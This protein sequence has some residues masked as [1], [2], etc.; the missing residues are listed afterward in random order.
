VVAAHSIQGDGARFAHGRY[1]LNRYKG[2]YAELPSVFFYLP[3][4]TEHLL[5]LI[6]TD[7]KKSN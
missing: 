3:I 4:A 1:P 2:V 7:P 6:A 5:S